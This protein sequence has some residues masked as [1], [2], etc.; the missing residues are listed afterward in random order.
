LRA[1]DPLQAIPLIAPWIQRLDRCIIDAAPLAV[2]E[3]CMTQASAELADPKLPPSETAPSEHCAKVAIQTAALSAAERDARQ[4]IA[5][6]P[7]I[8]RLLD[9]ASMSSASS[10][11]IG[12]SPVSPATE[13][14]ATLGSIPAGTAAGAGFDEPT[15]LYFRLLGKS[16]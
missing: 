13:S 9:D 11:P 3:Y 16:P 15:R 8:A 2:A 1:A 6:I 14:T 7:S 4:R 5:S 12:P 10:P